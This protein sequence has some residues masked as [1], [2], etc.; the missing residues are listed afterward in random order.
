MGVQEANY[1]SAISDTRTFAFSSQ[2]T[3]GMVLDDPSDIKKVSKKLTYHFQ[4]A[5]AATM[6]YDYTT[7]LTSMNEPTLKQLAKS[8]R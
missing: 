5:S 3:L 8:A 4:K 7:F 6:S 1:F 2:T